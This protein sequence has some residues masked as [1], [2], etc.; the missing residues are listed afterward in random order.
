MAYSSYSDSS[1]ADAEVLP[2]PYSIDLV[3]T[4]QRHLY[5]PTSSSHDTS[6]QKSI[7]Q[8]SFQAVES[9]SD[10]D[11]EPSVVSEVTQRQ[12][13]AI[14]LRGTNSDGCPSMILTIKSIPQSLRGMKSGDP[15]ILKSGSPDSGTPLSFSRPRRNIKSAPK[16]EESPSAETSVN[17]PK[18]KATASAISPAAKKQKFGTP[19]PS[20]KRSLPGSQSKITA[21]FSP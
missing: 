15:N 1:D 17:R 21:F 20:P 12:N 10:D 13:S 6:E 18:R 11:Y 19:K 3:P 8:K 16:K 4:D 14:I 7:V 2:I 9:K 5:L